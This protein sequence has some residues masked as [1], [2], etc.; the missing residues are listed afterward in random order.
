MRVKSQETCSNNNL[1]EYDLCAVNYINKIQ[2]Y[3]C[4]LTHKETQYALMNKLHYV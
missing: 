2:T 4:L 3:L 1:Q